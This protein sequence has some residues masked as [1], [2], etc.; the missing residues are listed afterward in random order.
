[1]TVPID[2][3]LLRQPRLLVPHKKPIGSVKIDRSNHLAQNLTIFTLLES[4]QPYV[5]GVNGTNTFAIS[6]GNGETVVTTPYGVSLH[7][8]DNTFS[9][10]YFS[11]AATLFPNDSQSTF[12][13]VRQRTAAG[14]NTS[15]LFGYVST[16]NNRVIA[17]IPYSDDNIYWHFGNNKVSSGGGGL[18]ISY[19]STN[20]YQVWVFVAG[21]TKGR[22]VWLNGVKLGGATNRT[23]SLP[24]YT[25]AFH[26]GNAGE[27]STEAYEQDLHA[28]GIFNEEWSDEKI[29]SFSHD[30]YQFLIPT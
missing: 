18:V 6:E 23:A 19:T 24:T 9:G 26:I 4:F 5:F 27:S 1:M 21:Q 10:V 25:G 8:Q 30:P 20:D 15:A 14:D 22:E 2:L 16:V 3:T 13:V 7:T 11:N 12:V 29:I 28:F 17:H